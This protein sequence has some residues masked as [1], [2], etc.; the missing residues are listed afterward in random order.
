MTQVKFMYEI[1]FMP[2]V[3]T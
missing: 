1:V 2:F 3:S